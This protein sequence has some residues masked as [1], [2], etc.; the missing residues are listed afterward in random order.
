MTA[1]ERACG[2]SSRPA[3]ALALLIPFAIGAGLLLTS[4]VALHETAWKFDVKRLLE[5]WLLPL[6]FGLVLLQPALRQAFRRQLQRTPRWLGSTLLAV[7]ALGMVSAAYNAGSAM[8]LAYSLA[9][10]AL[11][12]LLTAG[13]F[14][15]A[16]CR[17]VAGV[18]FD[19]VALLFLA[20]LGVAVGLQELLGVL[21]AWSAG[22]EFHPRIALMHFSW[23]RFYNQ[24]QSWSMP[25]LAALPLLFPGKPLA[26]LLCVATL[27]LNWYVVIATGGRG[28]MLAVGLAV[29]LLLLLLPAGRR[30]LATNH[31][32]GLLAGVL[33]YAAVALGHAQLPEPAAGAAAASPAR[34]DAAAIQEMGDSSGDFMEPLTGMRVTT[35]SGRIRMWRDSLRYVAGHSWLG[36]GPMNYACKGPT[37]RAGHPHSFPL[38]LLSEWGIPAAA[39]LFISV[40]FI[41]WRLLLRL[42]VM[43]LEPGPLTPLAGAVSTGVLAAAIHACLSGVLVMPASQVTGLLLG[44]WLLGLMNGGTQGVRV[45]FPVDPEPQ[46]NGHSRKNYSDPGRA[47]VSGKIYS[48]PGPAGVSGTIYSD[49]GRASPLT[50]GVLL[51]ALALSSALL[52]FGQ[53]EFA[54][55]DVRLEQTPLMDRLIPRFWQNGKACE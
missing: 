34:P 53:R 54:V 14:A 55:Q 15:L 20:V 36:I 33:I 11:L 21:A 40:A 1:P 47:S 24:M 9:D 51:T 35:S 4:T 38:Q 39:L 3:R 19:R 7:L 12:A 37:Y 45:N 48:D 50:L 41:A 18:N 31:A 25:A 52:V 8:G 27:A 10:V 2:D 30:Q 32:A 13:V 42:R 5:L 29:P 22:L 6:L 16:A 44:G 26:R 49:P 43:Q 46:S 17:E 23:P 28:T